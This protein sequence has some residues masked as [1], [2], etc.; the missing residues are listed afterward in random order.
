MKLQQESQSCCNPADQKRRTTDQQ[1]ASQRMAKLP[2]HRHGVY[3]YLAYHLCSSAVFPALGHFSRLC[4]PHFATWL[5]CPHSERALPRSCCAQRRAL[6]LRRR[7]V[8]ESLSVVSALWLQVRVFAWL[9]HVISQTALLL[10]C[11]QRASPKTSVDHH[12][13]SK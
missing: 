11:R 10:P 8:H 7:L 3:Y 12:Y 9:A 1:M 2:E 6:S 5:A 13:C 4:S